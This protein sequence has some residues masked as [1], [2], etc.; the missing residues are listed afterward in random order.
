[1][2]LQSYSWLNKETK[3]IQTKK[4]K[5]QKNQPLLTPLFKTKTNLKM[6]ILKL[7]SYFFSLMAI[8][9]VTI[10]L[11]SCEKKA[12]ITE[13]LNPI[14][15]TLADNEILESTETYRLEIPDGFSE[16]EA[17]KWVESLSYD[18]IIQ[19]GAEVD[20]EDN[21]EL[22]YC[23]YYPIRISGYTS[24]CSGC[25]NPPAKHTTFKY[26]YRLCNG[27]WFVSNWSTYTC[28]SYC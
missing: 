21:I 15:S 13:E 22:R 18:Q 28:K 7:K 6:K 24:S 9:T 11:S 17:E 2:I 1:V 3:F 5:E 16:E 10:F 4:S 26:R 12:S 25:G 20:F 8:I 14:Q 27:M 23:I 19:N